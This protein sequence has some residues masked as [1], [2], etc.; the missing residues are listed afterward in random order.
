M[1]NRKRSPLRCIVWLRD[2][3][4]PAND[5]RSGNRSSPEPLYVPLTPMRAFPPKEDI[6]TTHQYVVSLKSVSSCV[7]C[8][9]VALITNTPTFTLSWSVKSLPRVRTVVQVLPSLL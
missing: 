6:R 9:F 7:I 3:V 5:I 2:I 8:R 4:A 1:K